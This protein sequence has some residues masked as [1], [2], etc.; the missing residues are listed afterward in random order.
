MNLPRLAIESFMLFSGIFLALLLEGY[1]DDNQIR[2]R[3]ERLIGE[4]VLDLEE[5]ISDINNDIS[6]NGE[7]LLQTKTIIDAVN[8][9]NGQIESESA[10]ESIQQICKSYAFVVPKVSTFESIK[11]LGL[12]LIDD[13][14]LRTEITDFYELSLFRI[15]TAETRFYDFS[16]KECWPYVSENFAWSGPLEQTIRQ[17]NFGAESTQMDWM[18]DARARAVDLDELLQDSF[19]KFILH[20]ALIRRSFQLLH[21]ERGLVN[22]E[23]LKNRLTDYLR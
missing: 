5:T 10:F 14:L 21:Y 12:D 18:S 15:S 1:I 22:A 4:L 23:A 13:D 7:F 8:N 6:N 2:E 3:Q 17:V 19:F 9:P 16:M 11:S 20:E